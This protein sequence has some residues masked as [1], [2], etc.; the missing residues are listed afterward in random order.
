MNMVVFVSVGSRM[1]PC[2]KTSL[3]KNK[4]SQ[5]R[6][7]CHSL[8]AVICGSLFT[9]LFIHIEPDGVPGIGWF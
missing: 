4:H 2:V 8:Y 5:F 1:L 7:F 3:V 6:Q 9:L